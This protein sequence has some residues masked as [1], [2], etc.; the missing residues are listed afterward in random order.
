MGDG[1]VAPRQGFVAKL[2]THQEFAFL[3]LADPQVEEILPHLTPEERNESW[4]LLTTDGEDLTGG[5]GLRALLEALHWTRIL[6]SVLSGLGAIPFLTFLDRILKRARGRL[7]RLVPNVQGP[8]R[9][10]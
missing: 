6:G 4:H 1:S 10:P 3:P 8:R 2:D 9:Y 7:G 5:S